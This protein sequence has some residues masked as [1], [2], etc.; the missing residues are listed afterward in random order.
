MGH[1]VGSCS[2]HRPLRCSACLLGAQ[3]LR[4]AAAGALLVLTQRPPTPVSPPG[5]IDTSA[6]SRGRG[7]P[8]ETVRKSRAAS[9]SSSGG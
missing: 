4:C 2:P 8:Q 7:I 6:S 3:E 9:A 1:R 5:P